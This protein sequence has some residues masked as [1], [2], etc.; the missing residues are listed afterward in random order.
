MYRI[1]FFVLERSNDLLLYYVYVVNRRFNSKKDTFH[2]GR[3]EEQL[4]ATVTRNNEQDIE[5]T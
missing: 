3:T 4:V 5:L 2:K 1:T